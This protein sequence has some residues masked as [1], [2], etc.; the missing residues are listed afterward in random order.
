MRS[1]RYIIRDARSS[2]SDSS[3]A[4]PS[5]T[6]GGLMQRYNKLKAQQQQFQSGGLKPS[7]EAFGASC[8]PLVTP[9]VPTA[10]PAYGHEVTAYA[11][12]QAT[13]QGDTALLP[14]QVT[15]AP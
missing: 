13:W 1:S 6:I 2:L 4:F 9:S 3:K 15:S 14:D 8:D 5:R 7:Y 11:S 12:N 10:S